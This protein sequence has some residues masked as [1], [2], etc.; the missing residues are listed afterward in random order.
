MLTNQIL[1]GKRI[2]IVD[3]EADVRDTLSELLEACLIDT[4]PD[5]ETAKK[6]LN[7]HSYD[8]AIFDIMG[9]NGYEL[10]KYSEDKGIPALMLTAHSLS[11]QDLKKS[12]QDGA[13]AYIPKEKMA[14]VDAYLA[15]ILK[16]REKKIN[17]HGSWFRSLKSYFD[18]K[19]GVGWE[20]GDRIF[21]KNY[22]EKYLLTDEELSNLLTPSKDELSKIL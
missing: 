20:G 14:E 19:F 1:K 13:K 11:P 7:Q 15:E 8:A 2:L 3:D 5:F 6:F 17:K 10:L 18:R 4:A 16:I 9:V 21:W 12:I 22:E